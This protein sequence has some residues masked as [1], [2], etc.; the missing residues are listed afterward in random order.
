MVI[1]LNGCRLNDDRQRLDQLGNGPKLMSD[2]LQ[3]NGPK[4]AHGRS[5]ENRVWS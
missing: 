3:Q 5:R 2:P 4:V 1:R